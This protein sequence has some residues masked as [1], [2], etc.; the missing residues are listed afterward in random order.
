MDFRVELRNDDGN[1]GGPSLCISL[2]RAYVVY[3]ILLPS[4]LKGLSLVQTTVVE[5]H[6]SRD[7]FVDPNTLY[8]R[9]DFVDPNYF[10]LSLSLP[11]FL[12]FC[13]Q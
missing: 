2:G 3:A 10:P 6:T 5:A 7:D 13:F 4:R 12:F 1:V 9:D 8:L 11:L